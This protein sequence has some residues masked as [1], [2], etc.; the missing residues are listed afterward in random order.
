M[1]KS[2]RVVAIEYQDPSISI[3]CTHSGFSTPCALNWWTHTSL[4]NSHVVARHTRACQ[5]SNHRADEPTW[6]RSWSTVIWKAYSPMCVGAHGKIHHSPF[7]INLTESVHSDLVCFSTLMYLDLYKSH[8]KGDIVVSS[9]IR[10]IIMGIDSYS[11]SRIASKFSIL[12]RACVRQV[13]PWLDW[14]RTTAES[15]YLKHFKSISA[16]KASIMMWQHHI[17]LNKMQWRKET[18]WR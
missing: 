14:D 16:S 1:S 5:F 7:P 3:I 10:M 11:S 9:P 4:L 8:L 6:N 12:S 18:T 13:M 15:V 17:L 2:R